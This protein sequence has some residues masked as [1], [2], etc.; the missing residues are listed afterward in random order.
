[1][2]GV[3]QESKK[4]CRRYPTR[5]E[6]ASRKL[7]DAW[8]NAKGRRANL[9]EAEGLTLPS[10]GEDYRNTTMRHASNYFLRSRVSG[11]CYTHRS[12]GEAL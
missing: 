2:R 4:T 5:I 11:Q 12:S 10:P 7:G 8:E 9:A 3:A 6:S 1:M